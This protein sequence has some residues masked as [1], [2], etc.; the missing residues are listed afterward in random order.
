[1]LYNQTDLLFHIL[2]VLFTHIICHSYL[3][4]LYFNLTN[5]LYS[6]YIYIYNVFH[7]QKNFTLQQTEIRTVKILPQHNGGKI[8]GLP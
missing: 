7:I 1:M 6:I 8:E 4:R 5:L 2:F 3:E